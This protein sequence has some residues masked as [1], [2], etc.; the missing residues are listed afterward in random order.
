MTVGRVRLVAVVALLAAMVLP[1]C[2]VVGGSGPR[3]TLTAYFA[4]TVSLYPSSDVRILGLPAGKVK[5]VSV[6]GARV[7]VVLRVDKTVRVPADAQATIVPLS[8]I[9]ERYV[10]LYPAW[11][12]GE[13]AARDGDV[14]PLERTEVPVEPDEALAALKHFLDSLDPQATGNLIKNA[15]DDLRGNG[16]SLNDALAGLGHLTTTLAD[17]DDQLGRIIDNFDRF[18]SVVSTR[19]GQLG[20]VMDQFATMTGLLAQ[21]RRSIEGLVKGLSHVSVDALDLVSAN[22]VQ[23][24]RDLSVLT[25]TLQ[26][27]KVNIGQVEEVLDA[28]PIIVKGTLNGYSADYHRIDLRQTTSPTVAQALQAAGLGNLGTLV[29]IPIDVQCTPTSGP[30]PPVPGAAPAAR[31]APAPLPTVPSVGAPELPA[32]PPA[33]TTSTTNPVDSI[34]GL[35]GGGGPHLGTV[36]PGIADPARVADAAGGIGS[37]LRSAA[38][39]L[40]GWAG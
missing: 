31:A 35:L 17:K 40:L 7:K 4:K 18:T 5:S 2:S 14:I 20:R 39:A 21:E 24:D 23:L 8:L 1:A 33:P 13:P 30:L 11:T 32:T 15:A 34:T 9:G 36:T 16:Q 37:F 10:Q 38:H 25:T 22:R 28:G 19:E 12:K 27:V 6:D 29:C 26:A 3:Y